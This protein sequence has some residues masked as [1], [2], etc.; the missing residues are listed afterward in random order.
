[1][2]FRLPFT[3]FTALMGVAAL[4]GCASDKAPPHVVAAV[5]PTEQFPI[6]VAPVADEILLAPHGWLSAAQ[7]AALGEL[8][9]RWRET[10]ES[11]IVVEAPPEGPGAASAQAAAQALQ[12]YGVPLGSVQLTAVAAA[13]ADGP[14]MPIKVGFGRLAAVVPD[15]ASRWEDLSRTNANRTHAAFGCATSAN[16][17][18]QIAD[19]R[20]LGRPRTMTASDGDRRATVMGKY[21]KGES[22]SAERGDD[23]RGVV[24]DSIQ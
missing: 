21:R 13:S 1:M 3:V 5:T 7:S 24:S 17:A 23:E 15:C 20:D 16:L 11:P 2:R 14:P 12:G 18:A 22:T 10:G 4:P 9:T 6:E 8:A 19:P